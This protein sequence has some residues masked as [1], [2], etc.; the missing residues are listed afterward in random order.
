M[1]WGNP[2]PQDR[3]G[4]FD[5]FPSKLGAIKKRY[6]FYFWSIRNEKE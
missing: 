1:C 5:F 4:I 2:G 6:S 3:Y